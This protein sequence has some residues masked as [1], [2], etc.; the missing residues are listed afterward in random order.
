MCKERILGASW[1][2]SGAYQKQISSR[3]ETH[4]ELARVQ[5]KSYKGFWRLFGAKCELLTKYFLSIGMKCLDS[6]FSHT[7]C[8]LI[9]YEIFIRQI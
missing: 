3:L 6:C 9:R 4:H 7:K 1:F 8:Y 2:E 5:K